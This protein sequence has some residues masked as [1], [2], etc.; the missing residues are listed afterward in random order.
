LCRSAQRLILCGEHNNAG[1]DYHDRQIDDHLPAL[2]LCRQRGDADRRLSVL[3]RMPRL[4]HD[5][6]A[7][8]G[9]LLRFLLL[10]LGAMPT[11]SGRARIRRAA[12]L[13]R[14]GDDC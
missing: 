7:E 8:A 3:L 4:R 1:S 2:W 11:D 14:G 6:A 12:R 5:A 13:L 10:R 9:R